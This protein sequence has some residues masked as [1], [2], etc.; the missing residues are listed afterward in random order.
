[1]KIFEVIQ[2]KRLWG[3]L[4]G[5]KIP[6]DIKLLIAKH[7]KTSVNDKKYINLTPHNASDI[8]KIKPYW[9]TTREQIL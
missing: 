1:M 3:G 8:Q 7:V 4:N 6:D 2:R 5:N 9:T